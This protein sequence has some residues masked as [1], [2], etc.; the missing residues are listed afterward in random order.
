[1]LFPDEIARCGRMH[2]HIAVHLRG[3]VS[4]QRRVRSRMVEVELEAAQ[5]SL[6]INAVPE[7]NLVK[8]LAPD[9]SDQPL[10]EGMGNWR[11][12]NRFDFIYIENTEICQPTVI[13]E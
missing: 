5:L 2:D 9:A 11:V 7:E 6:Q 1:M 12:G 13:G 4:R 8:K 10:H 3:R